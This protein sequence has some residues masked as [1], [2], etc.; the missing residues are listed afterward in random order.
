MDWLKEDILIKGNSASEIKVRTVGSSPA[1]KTICSK[2]NKC[3]PATKK[4]KILLRNGSCE[5]VVVEMK[6]LKIRR[7]VKYF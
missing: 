6:D 4:K 1:N 5:E 3:R 7:R 2:N